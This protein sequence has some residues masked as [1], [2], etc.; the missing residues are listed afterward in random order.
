MIAGFMEAV[1]QFER[2]INDTGYIGLRRMGDDEI[3]GNEE[4]S[5][6]IE[7]YLSLSMGDVTC[8]ECWFTSNYSF[9]T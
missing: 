4:T 7:K 9:F 2:I 6:I 1:G 8:L 5:G 3:L